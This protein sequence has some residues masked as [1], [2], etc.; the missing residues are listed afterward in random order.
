MRLADPPGRRSVRAPTNTLAEYGPGGAGLPYAAGRVAALAVD[1]RDAN[2]AYLGAAG[3]GVWKTMTGAKN[4]QPLTDDQPSLATGSIA[5][6]PSA[7]H[8]LCRHRRG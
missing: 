5:L 6:A 8:R 7:R 1:P 2:V 3:G 4:W